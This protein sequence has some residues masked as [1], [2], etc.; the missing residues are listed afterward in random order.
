MQYSILELGFAGAAILDEHL[1]RGP[2]D[3]ERDETRDLVRAPAVVFE[4][5]EM[6]EDPLVRL[7]PAVPH[8]ETVIG[9]S[10]AGENGSIRVVG[11]TPHSDD[12]FALHMRHEDD[13]L[14]IG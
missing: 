1:D 5:V 6:T 2:V 4:P 14:P 11:Q 8:A 3:I 7:E 13:V 12:R 10:L 9:T